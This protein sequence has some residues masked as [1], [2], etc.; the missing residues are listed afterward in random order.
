VRGQAHPIGALADQTLACTLRMRA[1]DVDADHS[2]PELRLRLAFGFGDDVA[3]QT[4]VE[5][6]TWQRT[7][8]VEHVTLLPGELVKLSA[9]DVDAFVD[10]WIGMDVVVFDGRTPLVFEHPSF[11]AECRVVPP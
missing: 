5:S 2:P 6:S 10:D 7:F 8:A 1:R 3:G 4:W 11:A 9:M